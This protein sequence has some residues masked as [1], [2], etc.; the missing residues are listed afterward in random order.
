MAQLDQKILFAPDETCA[1]QL[2]A[3]RQAFGA[4]PDAILIADAGGRIVFANARAEELFGFTHEELLTR[5]VEDL[6]PER[7]RV[8]HARHRAAFAAAPRARPM[9]AARELVALCRDGSELEVDVGLGPITLDGQELVIAALRDATERRRAERDIRLIAEGLASTTGADFFRSLVCYLAAAL[10]VRYALV[11]AVAGDCGCKIRTLAVWD[12]DGPAENFTYSLAG[13]PCEMVVGRTPC[14]YPAGVQELFPEDGHLRKLGAESY[15]GLPLFGSRD[16]PLGL[17]AVLDDKPLPEADSNEAIVRIFAARAA[18]E[19]ERLQAEEAR[20]D[21]D[22]RLQAIFDESPAG[23]VVFDAEG[24]IVESNPSFCKLTGY[25]PEELRE[26]PR[27]SYTH[28][29]DLPVQLELW[30]ELLAGKRRRYEL[31]KR[32]L[33]KDGTLAWGHVIASA[34]DRGPGR[35]PFYFSIVQDVTERT[36]AEHALRE[37]NQRFELAALA[38]GA[39]VY[40]WDPQMGRGV[41]SR[42]FEEIFGYPSENLE[43]THAWWLDSVHPDDRE[44]AEAAFRESVRTGSDYVCEYRFRAQDGRY[45]DVLDRALALRDEAGRM[46]RM[47]GAMLDLTEHRLLEA[48]LRQFEKLEALGRLAGGIAHDFNNVLSVITGYGELLRSAL[49]SGDPRQAEVAEILRAAESGEGLTRQLLTYSRG[50]ELRP[51]VLDLNTVVQDA[52]GM[53]RRVLGR[54]VELVCRLAPS[55]GRVSADAGQLEQVIVNLA[56]NARDAMPGGGSVTIETRDVVVGSGRSRAGLERGAYVLLAVS[57]TGAGIDEQMRARIFEPF[58]TTKGSRGTG[59]GLATVY[60]VVTE[61]GGQIHVESEPGQGTAFELYFPRVREAVA[62]GETVA[63]EPL[64]R[65]AASG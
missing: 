39:A 26:L 32:Y 34:V 48:R 53:L 55:L 56:V 50:R 38:A 22:S 20:R 10:G 42:G 14:T 11:G 4:L 36:T 1:M 59:L 58:F 9:G 16:Q 57:D 29:E 19:L 54:D 64:R 35:P 18:A 46:T 25:T 2:E 43:A 28:P 5:T 41:L 12:G 23:I 45:R 51:E 6:V 7:F 62:A 40:D 30:Q 17:I 65:A 63:D 13:T 15:L 37:A 27:A 49:E 44:Q 47:V 21:S 24:R 31:E 33:R 3:L 60:S 61:S 52:A 8:R